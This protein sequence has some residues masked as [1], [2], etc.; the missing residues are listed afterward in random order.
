MLSSPAS[1]LSCLVLARRSA[2][3]EMQRSAQA[4]CAD[5]CTAGTHWLHAPRRCGAAE[6]PALVGRKHRS[7]L[8][9]QA[10]AWGSEDTL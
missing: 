7:L 2:C 9:Q 10:Y 3:S 5:R 4:A 6:S 1:A 8:I